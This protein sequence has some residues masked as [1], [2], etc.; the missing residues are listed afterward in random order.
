M[1]KTLGPIPLIFCLVA[2]ELCPFE[3]CGQSYPARAIRLIVPFA[4]GGGVDIVARLLGIRLSD[5]L[6]QPV[7]I[8]NR[9]GAG[10]IVGT[11][12][13][14]RAAPDGYTIGQGNNSTHGVN[15]AFNPKL[16]Y[17][18]IKNFSPIT[19]FVTSPAL[20]I[21]PNSVPVKSV[22][23][24]IELAKAKP[25]QLNFGSYG[26]ATITHLW[27]ELFGYTTGA[28]IVHIPY[29]SAGTSPF[30]AALS[31]E[32]HLLFASVGGSMGQLQSGRF[33]A[34]GTTG[35]K[36]SQFFSDVPT[37]GEQGVNGFETGSWFVLF[38][39]AGMP[40]P[41]V[42]RLYQEVARIVNAPEFKQKLLKDGLEPL[43]NSPEECAEIIRVDLAKWTKLV[44]D[45]GIKGN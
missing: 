8:D 35:A 37:L 14:A 33:R 36:R 6:G 34:L 41:I 7:V 39:P 27:G 29:T 32:V 43:G 5:N 3:A 21:T 25:G 44:K 17:D 26:I 42:S 9:P 40:R 20:L 15:Q 28:K 12:L 38:G 45:T 16:S 10:G 19:I 2:L 22:K 30:T 18:S 31:G 4:P 23:E 1:L 24:L 11:E 13:V